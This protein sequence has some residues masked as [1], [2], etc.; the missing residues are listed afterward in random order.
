MIPVFLKL[1]FVP[2]SMASKLRRV[3]WFGGFLFVAS[4]TSLLIPIT[5]GGTMYAWSSWRT[6][7]PLILG[8]AGLIG[9]IFYEK[10]V[11]SDPLIRL[12]IFTQRTAAVNY[13]GTF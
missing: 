13:V 12:A 5:W 7:V 6:L 3:D 4:C 8:A 1:N 10:F 2:T 11:A 9:F